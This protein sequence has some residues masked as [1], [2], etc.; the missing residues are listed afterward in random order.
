MNHPSC[1]S[2][3]SLQTRLLCASFP[4]VPWRC[5]GHSPQMSLPS[6]AQ[7]PSTSC[8]WMASSYGSVPEARRGGDRVK[9]KDR[10]GQG[11]A[12]AGVA[13]SKQRDGRHC[14]TIHHWEGPALPFTFH[15]RRMHFYTDR[16]PAAAG[17]LP[18]WLTVPGPMPSLLP[19]EN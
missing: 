17:I 4:C 3:L 10:R 16:I 2:C 15:Q 5:E 7:D 11:S 9:V 1:H 19:P 6:Q 14:N 8:S 13:G 18:H 12:C